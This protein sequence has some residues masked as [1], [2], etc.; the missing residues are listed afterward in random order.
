REHRM[1][2]AHPWAL[3]LLAVPVL[4]AWVVVVGRKPGVVMPFDHRPHRRSRVPRLLL[5]VFDLSPLMLAG[6]AIVMLAGPMALRQPHDE[7]MLSNIEI[8]LDVSGSM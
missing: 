3:L 5:A 4:L 7:R 6:V 2:F 8:C 1:T